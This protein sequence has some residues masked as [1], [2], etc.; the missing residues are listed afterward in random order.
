MNEVSSDDEMRFLLLEKDLDNRDALNM[1]YDNN[2]DKL[3][4][5]PF[6]QNIVYQIWTSPYNNSQSFFCASANHKLLWNYNHCRY[7]LEARL[8]FYKKRSLKTMGCHGF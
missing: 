5:H 4:E 2:I 8:R 3:L 6:A 7:D 1:I